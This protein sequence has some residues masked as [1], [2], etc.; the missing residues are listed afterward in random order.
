MLNPE[1]SFFESP[2]LQDGIIKNLEII[3]ETAN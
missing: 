2:L 1:E 3:G